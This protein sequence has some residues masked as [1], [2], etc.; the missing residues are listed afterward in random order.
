MWFTPAT[1]GTFDGQCAE[2]CGMGHA[3]MRLKLMVERPADFTRWVRAQRRGPREPDS[4][5]AAGHGRQV[6]LE[7]G[8]AGCHTIRGVAP[9]VIGP[10]L[11]HLA[12]RTTVA[13][14]IYPNTPEALARWIEDPPARKPG[15]LMP[16][17]GLRSD[18]IADLVAYLRSLE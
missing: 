4:A 11:T 9:G 14:A 5:S 12:S 10:D 2:L 6:F 16:K 18:Q 7:S 15:T 17:L 13:G 3:N 8:C 1:A